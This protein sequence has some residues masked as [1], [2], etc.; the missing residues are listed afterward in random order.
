MLLK[1]HEAASNPFWKSVGNKSSITKE[2]SSEEGLLLVAEE[3]RAGRASP[4]SIRGKGLN[5]SQD[6]RTSAGVVVRFFY[7]SDFLTGSQLP[8][9]N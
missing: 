8:E 5:R 7:L 4:G 9:G 1:G 3:A 2:T 6:F